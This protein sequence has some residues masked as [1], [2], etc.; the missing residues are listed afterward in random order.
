MDEYVWM[1]VGDKGQAS[2]AQA[3]VIDVI[4]PSV[5]VGL[6][7]APCIL[8]SFHSPVYL[9]PLAMCSVPLPE[10]TPFAH[11]PSYRFPFANLDSPDWL[12]D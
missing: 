8:P 12:M 4:P 11:S 7:Y 5:F 3:S 9:S 2:R 1:Y 6:E 10:I